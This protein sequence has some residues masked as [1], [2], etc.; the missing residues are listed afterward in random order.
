MPTKAEKEREARIQARKKEADKKAKERKEK[1][2]K[3]I[4]RIESH[5]AET[6]KAQ[7][8]MLKCG[9]IVEVLNTVQAKLAQE[10]GFNAICP[11]N[12]PAT[13]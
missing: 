10:A 4:K 3:I 5:R 9:V 13:I 11:Y 8:S 6:F 1:E 12:F 2:A 7:L